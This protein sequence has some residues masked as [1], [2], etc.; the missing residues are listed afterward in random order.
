MSA[1]PTCHRNVGLTDAA[2]DCSSGRL[3]RILRWAA[4]FSAS[5]TLALGV[6][7]G[8]ARA[9][10]NSTS[11]SRSSSRTTSTGQVSTPG[12]TQ[13]PTIV[14]PWFS[15]GI[16]NQPITEAPTAEPQSLTSAPP[17][18]V[19][20]LPSF[21]VATPSDSTPY[22]VT[23]NAGNPPPSRLAPSQTIPEIDP[24]S[25]ANALTLLIGGVIMLTDRRRRICCC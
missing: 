22:P 23:P 12:A 13:P 16:A 8:D 10:G 1:A 24:A 17:T 4:A 25:A 7:V 9:Q 5:L 2:R 20:Q 11:N 3:P 6:S 18:S 15:P 14:L 19:I 21:S